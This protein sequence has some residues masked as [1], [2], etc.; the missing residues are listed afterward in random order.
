MLK[1]K[2]WTN[3]RYFLHGQINYL[4]IQLPHCTVSLA[5]GWLNLQALIQV[6]LHLL[7]LL[8]VLQVLWMLSLLL[9]RERAMLPQLAVG[10]CPLVIFV[11]WLSDV[12]RHE[13]GST[14]PVSPGPNVSSSFFLFVHILLAAA[15]GPEEGRGLGT[16]AVPENAAD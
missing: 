16:A 1:V 6:P 14:P 9:G 13:E 4:L 12:P 7:F 10:D 2:S 5:L 15:L 3:N 8:T 11:C